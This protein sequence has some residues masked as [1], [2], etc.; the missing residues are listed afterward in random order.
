MSDGFLQ[1]IDGAARLM[2]IYHGV[3]D[4]EDKRKSDQ[5]ERDYRLSRDT[6]KDTQWQ[7]NFEQSDSQF[8]QN[9][10]YQYASLAQ[11]DKHHKM[12]YGLS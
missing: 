11:S 6:V 5:L 10:E 7:K 4:R 9:K 1:G 12:N 3:R 8:K 2:S